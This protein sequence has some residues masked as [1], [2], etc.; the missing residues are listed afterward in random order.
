MVCSKLGL[1]TDLNLELVAETTP[2][3]VGAD[4]D[5]LCRETCYLAKD[6]QVSLNDWKAA[7]SRMRPSV[8]RQGPSFEVNYIIC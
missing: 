4:L 5:L 1:Q 6:S 7:I 3:Y 2:G 8:M